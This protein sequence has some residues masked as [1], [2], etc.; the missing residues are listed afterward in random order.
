[1][2]P[3]VQRIWS[4]N[5]SAS[6]LA[7]PTVLPSVLPRDETVN[8]EYDIHTPG[9]CH[10]LFPIRSFIPRQVA[11]HLH[12]CWLLFGYNSNI[13]Y[14]KTHH[15]LCVLDLVSEMLFVIQNCS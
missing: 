7:S 12:A 8:I 5:A 13:M 10:C 15:E 3:V 2:L 1:M 14:A 6:P 4:S 11:G 9:C